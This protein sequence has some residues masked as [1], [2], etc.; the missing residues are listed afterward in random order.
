LYRHTAGF[1]QPF[2]SYKMRAHVIAGAGYPIEKRYRFH[3]PLPD[4]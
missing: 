1:N 2:D 4:C 3:P